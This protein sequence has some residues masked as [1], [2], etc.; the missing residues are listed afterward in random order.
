MA[1]VASVLMRAQERD[2]A[3]EFDR[4][5]LAEYDR[6]VRIAYR[7]LGDAHEAE[8]V[9]QEVFSSYYS[10]HAPDAPYAAPWLHRAASHTALNVVR[11]KRRQA[12]REERTGTDPTITTHA[13]DPQHVAV[14]LE[15]RREVRAA[16]A[17]LPEKSAA[18][19]AMRYSGLSYAEVGD[20]LGVSTGQ[21]GTLLRR[22]EAALRKEID[23]ETR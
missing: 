20:A 14:T 6:V 3:R 1:H 7:V 19:L 11:G 4:L 21:I 13:P 22:A 5:F 17:R 8:D 23:R 16:L 9:A 2:P 12:R 18:V 10:K 15:D